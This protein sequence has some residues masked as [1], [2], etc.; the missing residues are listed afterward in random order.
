[1]SNT[2]TTCPIIRQMLAGYV[3]D[4]LTPT[5][6][7]LVSQH[8]AHCA[9]CLVEVNSQRE[10]LARLPQMWA[11][12]SHLKTPPTV[13]ENLLAQIKNQ[14]T[15]PVSAPSPEDPARSWLTPMR[16]RSWQLAFW[17][18][19]A[20]LLGTLVW[21]ITT[22]RRLTEERQAHQQLLAQ[23]EA[24]QGMLN[25]VDSQQT[26]T[27][28][29]VAPEAGAN[30]PWGKFYF[31]PERKDV[32]LAA[33]KMPP[34]PADHAYYAWLRSGDELIL[35]GTMLVDTQ[36]FGWVYFTGEQLPQSYEAAG[37]TMQPLGETESNQ[38]GII[39]WRT[40]P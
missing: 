16:T 38:Q 19:I 12:L 28:I 3:L 4:A 39:V 14:N 2:E 18:A 10:L 13:K 35:A 26:A 34:L 40:E 21:G 27:Q 15:V 25:V 31:H 6:T 36:G 24:Q 22:N 8:I 30:D 32:V 23:F 37:F 20:L 7:V 17:A 1:M 9:D 33:W 11:Q 5:E 29:L